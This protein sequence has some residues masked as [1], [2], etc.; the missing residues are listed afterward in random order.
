VQA[1]SSSW[2][3]GWWGGLLILTRP[4]GLLLIGLVALV[5][6]VRSDR[7]G[8]KAVGQLGIALFITLSPG[9]WFNW[10]AGGTLFPNTFY[11]KQSEYAVLTS[12][13]SIWLEAIGQ[14]LLAPLAGGLF[15]L[16]PGL[17][18]W[19]VRRPVAR[20]SEVDW[21]TWLPLLWIAAHVA[22]YA[23]RLP[24]HYQHG[25]YLI[26]IIPVLAIY[27]VAGV[28]RMVARGAG[29][30]ERVF[31][32][33]WVISI[34]LIVIG[35]VPIGALTYTTDVSIINGEMVAVARWLDANTPP[36]A[37]IAAHD[38]GA[39]GYFARRPLLDLAGL[40]SPEVIPFIRDEARLLDW[41]QARGAQYLVTFP[42]W[43]PELVRAPIFSPVFWGQAA[44]S[45][46]HLAVY[47]VR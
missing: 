16:M 44:D 7:G 9:L 20:L 15:L 33:V 47:V 45:P 34:G 31:N 24:V 6:L 37:I 27:S 4:E 41:L 8:L 30:W 2:S 10:Q 39:I 28:A 3:I 23:L 40:I 32:R 22:S 19:L 11:A 12:S 13:V 1:K 35:Y 18:A 42:N 43:Y 36:G 14:L 25:R 17:L 26:P 5:L 21:S 29:R 46:E 38:I